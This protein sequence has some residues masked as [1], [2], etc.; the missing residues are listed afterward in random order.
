MPLSNYE[1]QLLSA[2]AAH[3]V[4]DQLHNNDKKKKTD[5]YLILTQMNLS[6]K[7][8]KKDGCIHFSM[9]NPS[10]MRIV[11]AK[12][13]HLSG[14]GITY[15]KAQKISDEYFDF[16]LSQGF[17][18]ENSAKIPQLENANLANLRNKSNFINIPSVQKESA[19]KIE[20]S[21][22]EKFVKSILSEIFPGGDV[23]FLPKEHQD[24]VLKIREEFSSKTDGRNLMIDEFMSYLNIVFEGRFEEFI[25]LCNVD[26]RKE[27]KE[28]D[29]VS[30]EQEE[31][32]P[33]V[34]KTPSEKSLPGK[35]KGPQKSNNKPK[36]PDSQAR[37]SEPEAR[38]P[39]NIGQIANSLNQLPK[40]KIK[41][42]AE[43]YAEIRK[44]IEIFIKN[45]P[46]SPDLLIL[47]GEI[48]RVAKPDLKN[49]GRIRYFDDLAENILNK[50]SQ[51]DLKPLE[52]S[53][54]S[55]RKSLPQHCQK[56]TFSQYC[57][58]TTSSFIAAQYETNK[59]ESLLKIFSKNVGFSDA[60][61]SANEAGMSE[62][63]FDAAIYNPSFLLNLMQFLEKNPP[64]DKK[65]LLQ[66]EV[67][68]I[69]VFLQN[70]N[71][72]FDKIGKV[73]NF[74]VEK[75]L[76]ILDDDKLK[77]ELIFEIFSKSDCGVNLGKI[78][79]EK[80]LLKVSKMFGG[81]N[82]HN[83]F[84]IFAYF[85][86]EQLI[87]VAKAAVRLLDFLNNKDENDFTPLMIS[88]QSGTKGV[89]KILK[90]LPEDQRLG[91]I[92]DNFGKNG[93][94]AFAIAITYGQ[95]DLAEKMLE[96]LPEN[97]KV[98]LAQSQDHLQNDAFSLC[99]AYP[100]NYGGFPIEEKYL[101]FA[102]RVLEVAS[103][104]HV[105]KHRDSRGNSLALFSAQS[106]S[107]DLFKAML[108][109][110]P[111]NEESLSLLDAKNRNGANA[112]LVIEQNISLASSSAMTGES[113]L[114]IELLSKMQNLLKAKKEKIA[115][116]IK[117]PSKDPS[118]PS[119]KVAENTMGGKG[120]G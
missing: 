56:L 79:K 98:D 78:F 11:I 60:L 7:K 6:V 29:S 43:S 108:N 89:E 16:V 116:A 58:K 81:K 68:G 102:E 85:G 117:N 63:F 92:K 22:D 19:P 119:S 51:I 115:A 42:R 3:H 93:L 66:Q 18:P 97:K 62:D 2:K 1:K 55:T 113:K 67:V 71:I 12:L 99:I 46:K 76:T 100:I 73:V 50:L 77:Q 9:M 90:A 111:D 65:L 88:A 37:V 70:Q 95:L 40:K 36:Q 72:P 27:I 52:K 64:T 110:L 74:I 57:A 38:K 32:F 31:E 33:V 101:K 49:T 28:D 47:L 44:D 82:N 30:Q 13:I 53:F 75:D 96:S 61:I 35:N 107:P 112:E 10:Q 87:N 17:I 120:G 118:H 106:E 69:V 109:K 24:V 23:S 84:N 91:H 4:F 26:T 59:I 54:V 39:K 41:D 20:D 15:D 83:L 94:N 114:R 21:E 103:V 105:L 80:D 86:K 8:S 104:E 5:S 45:N 25:L 34:A 48:L 14:N